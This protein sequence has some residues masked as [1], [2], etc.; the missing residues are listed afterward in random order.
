MDLFLPESLLNI[1]SRRVTEGPYLCEECGTDFTPVWRAIGADENSL[2]LYCDAC[3][4]AAQKKKLRQE[5]TALLRK[6]F[7]KVMEKE[8]VRACMFLLH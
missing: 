2:N 4:K 3:V 6:A 8:Q 1:C 7:N 5:H